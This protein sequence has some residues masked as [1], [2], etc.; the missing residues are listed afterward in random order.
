MAQRSFQQRTTYQEGRR[1]RASRQVRA[2]AKN[3]RFGR[4]GRKSMWPAGR[5]P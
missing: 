2:M 1:V 5:A 3:A 4:R